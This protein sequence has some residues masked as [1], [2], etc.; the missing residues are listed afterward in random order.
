[1]SLKKSNNK[2][3]TFTKPGIFSRAFITSLT[4][5]G[6]KDCVVKL[7]LEHQ[8]KITAFFPNGLKPRAKGASAIQAPSFALV[9]IVLG[10]DHQLSR[11]RSV[12]IDPKLYLHKFCVKSFAYLAYLAELLEKLLPEA[13]AYDDEIYSLA[14]KFFAALTEHGPQTI[15]LRALEMKLL[16]YCGYWPDFSLAQEAISQDYFYDP[17]NSKLVIEP[18][19]ITQVLSKK[20]IILAESLL[21]EPFF[22]E[23]SDYEPEVLLSLGRLFASRLRLLGLKNLNSVQFLK[24]L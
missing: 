22:S 19:P 14:T 24:E 6:E 17:V 2:T 1:M 12:E 4:R 21:K 20:T 9:E 18:S 11:L 16:D 23:K 5:Y 15:I 10:K 13:E 8:G 7:L 3:F